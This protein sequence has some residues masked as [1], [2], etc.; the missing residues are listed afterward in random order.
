MKIVFVQPNVGF[1]GHTWEALGIGYIAAYL[2]Q[3]HADNL[4]ITFFPAFTMKIV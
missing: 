1:K 4:D 3:N 2:K